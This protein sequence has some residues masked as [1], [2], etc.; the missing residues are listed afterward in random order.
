MNTAM[1][2]AILVGGCGG[3]IAFIAFLMCTERDQ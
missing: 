2:L 3:F 1:A